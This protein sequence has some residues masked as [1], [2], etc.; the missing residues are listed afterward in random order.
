METRV[1]L[2]GFVFAF[3]TATGLLGNILVLL[4]YFLIAHQQKKLVP[5]EI[6]LL[7]LALTNLVYDITLAFPHTVFIF[8]VKYL[9]SDSDCKFD[10]YMARVSRALS[11]CLTSLLSSCQC[12]AL[13]SRR[14]R[15]FRLN[16]QKHLF[17]G[18]FL[19]LFV[20]MVSSMSTAFFARASG[21][22]TNLNY[23]FDLGYC[24]VIY[25]DKTSFHL[26]GFV[27]FARDFI[28]VVIM[29]ISSTHILWILYRH[30]KQV[31]GIR[32]S[33]RMRQDSAE[34][35]AAKLV[36][37]LVLVYVL[38]FGIDN[39]LWFYQFTLRRGDEI[40]TDVNHLLS[41][42]YASVFPVVVLTFNRKVRSN[43]LRCLGGEAD[44]SL[45]SSSL[46]EGKC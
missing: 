31:R 41:T 9:V 35:Q 42:V 26:V 15:Y 6:I 24:L 1:A 7:A 13:A 19:L 16:S 10:L 23:V 33:D 3:M 5:A 29:T 44:Q 11:I 25:R 37:T 8:Q 43:L 21:N 12:A 22:S 46:S 27:A 36:V 38:I 32:G 28:F 17:L 45:I 14:W 40:L 30:A 39:G 2:R 20:S 18:V 34:S 4:A